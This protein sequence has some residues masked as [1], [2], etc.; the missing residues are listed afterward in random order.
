MVLQKDEK[1]KLICLQVSLGYM[2]L[3]PPQ[4]RKFY[5]RFSYVSHKTQSN[6]E[7]SWYV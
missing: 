4:K 6:K 7:K 5:K 1:V 2:T 3:P